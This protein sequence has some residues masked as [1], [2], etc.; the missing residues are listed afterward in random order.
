[1]ALGRQLRA[2]I[3]KQ[4]S[5]DDVWTA[6]D[7]LRQGKPLTAIQSG[8]HEELAVDKLQVVG[9]PWAYNDGGNH[10]VFLFYTSG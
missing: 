2:V 8:V 7:L 10:V 3:I 6:L 1:M 4:A 9:E 5:L